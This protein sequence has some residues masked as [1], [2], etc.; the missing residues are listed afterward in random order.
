[1]ENEENVDFIQKQLQIKLV[2]NKYFKGYE[3]Q[4]DTLFAALFIK[5]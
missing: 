1:L 4:A 3:M 2:E 5:E